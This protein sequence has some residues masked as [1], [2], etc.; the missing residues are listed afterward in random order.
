MRPAPIDQVVEQL[1]SLFYRFRW[2]SLGQKEPRIE[3]WPD[4]IETKPGDLLNVSFG[5]I[6]VSVL[7]PKPPGALRTDQL[8]HQLF[9]AAWTIG[10]RAEFPHVT[11][12]QKP[13]A[14][15]DSP[16]NYFFAPFVHDVLAIRVQETHGGGRA[17]GTR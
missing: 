8:F 13:I 15:S 10:L 7:S 1:E 5:D 9:D 6:V 3:R 12:R 16:E 4:R 14:E 2:I 11:F 17:N